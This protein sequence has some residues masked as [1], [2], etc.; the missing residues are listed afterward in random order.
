MLAGFDQAHPHMLVSL[1]HAL[2]VGSHCSIKSNLNFRL[3]YPGGTSLFTALKVRFQGNIISKSAGT[4][5]L[6]LKSE[7]TSF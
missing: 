4:S 2:T 7:V 1:S 3:V 5:L 6:S